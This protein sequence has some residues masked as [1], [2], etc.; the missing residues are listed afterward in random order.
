M[1]ATINA[2]TEVNNRTNTG[3]GNTTDTR[4]RNITIVDERN[5]T[6]TSGCL[7]VSSRL[8]NYNDYVR[9]LKLGWVKFCAGQLDQTQIKK[10]E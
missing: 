10:T 3:M 2:S 8:A 4:M 7:V 6:G 1:N 9:G 5:T